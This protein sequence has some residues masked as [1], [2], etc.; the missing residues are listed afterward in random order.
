MCPRKRGKADKLRRLNDCDIKAGSLRSREIRRGG[1]PYHNESGSLL[2][3]TAQFATLC[4]V[5]RNDEH[6]KSSLHS[7]LPLRA[8]SDMDRCGELLP[9]SNT[10]NLRIPIGFQLKH[11]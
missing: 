8:L 9:T 7:R 1:D 6:T 3:R 2:K 11:K 5:F 10:S 4:V